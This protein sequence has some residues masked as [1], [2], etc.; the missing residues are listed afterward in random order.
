MGV[1]ERPRPRAAEG[2]VW[3]WGC[4]ENGGPAWVSPH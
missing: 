1:T 2:P 4:G 3:D